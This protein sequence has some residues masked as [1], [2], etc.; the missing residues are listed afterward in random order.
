MIWERLELQAKV[1]QKCRDSKVM[2][3]CTQKEGVSD[4]EYDE[5]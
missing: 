3:T 4:D 5:E 2:S 1:N